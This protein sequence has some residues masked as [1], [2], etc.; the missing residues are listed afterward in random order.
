MKEYVY[1]YILVCMILPPLLFSSFLSLLY[2]QYVRVPTSMINYIVLYPQYKLAIIS[3]GGV[4]DVRRQ[5]GRID[6]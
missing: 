6:K 1:I 5:N 3:D 2:P 4:G